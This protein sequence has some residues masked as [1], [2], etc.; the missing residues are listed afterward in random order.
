VP[1][2]DELATLLAKIQAAQ[3]EGHPYV[4]S[5]PSRHAQIQQMRKNGKWNDRL[6]RLPISNL[7]PKL[8]ALLKRAELSHLTFHDVRRTCLTNW[9]E[10]R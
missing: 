10:T 4:F 9:A 5:P 1:L 3:P 7:H 6:A 2:V 8:W